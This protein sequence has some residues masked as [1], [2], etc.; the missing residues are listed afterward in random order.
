MRAKPNTFSI[1]AFGSRLLER[2]NIPTPG[3][4]EVHYEGG[5]DNTGL[6]L[7]PKWKGNLAMAYTVGPW[8]AQLAEEWISKNEINTTWVEGVDVDDNW[9]PNYFNTNLKLGWAGDLY[10]AQST[11]I[12][13]YVTN[14]F[15]RDPMIIPSYNSRT[16][17]QIVSNNFDAYGRSYN[18]AINFRW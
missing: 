14:L 3:A 10:G 16:G 6:I 8:T 1:R 7:Y 17:S 5:F 15:D 4:P 13:L 12:A 11:E 2:T 18:L 9:L